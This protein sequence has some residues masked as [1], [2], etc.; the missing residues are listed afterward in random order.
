MA[1][2]YRAKKGYV[3][4]CW[5]SVLNRDG[6]TS[7]VEVSSHPRSPCCMPPMY[8]ILKVSRK[9]SYLDRPDNPDVF[10]DGIPKQ[11]PN[12]EDVLEVC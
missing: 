8:S 9:P 4:N 11:P 7:Q 3:A 5:T 12:E 6:R 2:G 10:R 1:F